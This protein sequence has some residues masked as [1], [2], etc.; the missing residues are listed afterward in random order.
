MITTVETVVVCC[1][2]ATFYSPEGSVGYLG[3]SKTRGRI[4]FRTM[5]N[6]HFI[7]FDRGYRRLMWMRG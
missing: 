1:N 6:I 5:Q 7:C 3:N 4:V 2:F